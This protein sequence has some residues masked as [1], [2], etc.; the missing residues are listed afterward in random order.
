MFAMRQLD[1]LH[2]LLLDTLESS[3]PI[4]QI[5]LTFLS[6]VIGDGQEL[7][8]E[9]CTMLTKPLILLLN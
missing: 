6:Q 1:V 5:H 3:L 4:L 8:T 7:E 2:L 9:A